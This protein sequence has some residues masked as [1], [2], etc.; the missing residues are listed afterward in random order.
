MLLLFLANGFEEIEAVATLDVLRRAELDVK[1]VGI[2]GRAVTGAHGVTVM[3]D[4]AQ[5]DCPDFGAL[6][7]VVLPGG[8]PGTLNLEAS[9]L[10]QSA[11]DEA[12]GRGLLVAA[13]CAAPSILGK[14][15]LLR[16]RRAVCFDGFEGFLEG[17]LPGDAP[18]C[19]DENFITARG[20][21]VAVDFGLEIVRYFLGGERAAL[22]RASMK[23]PA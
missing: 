14:K 16:G 17:A 22:L 21:G 4:Y 20:A 13:I 18:V 3:A 12:A 10:V 1:T 11:V 9:P 6:Q 5:G 19:S 7:G 15:G 8:M 23:C 2:G